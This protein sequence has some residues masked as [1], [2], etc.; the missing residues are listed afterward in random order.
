[1]NVTKVT[2]QDYRSIL[3]WSK[4][5]LLC[6]MTVNPIA[7]LLIAVSVLDLVLT[8]CPGSPFNSIHLVHARLVFLP[9]DIHQINTIAAGIPRMI[10]TQTSM[11]MNE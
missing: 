9:R 6:E 5:K 4:T 8:I 7:T 2:H 11:V 1:M 10:A 3:V